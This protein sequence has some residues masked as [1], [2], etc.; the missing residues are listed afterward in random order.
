[1]KCKLTE[2][3]QAKLTIA[4]EIKQTQWR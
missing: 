4:K 2:Q 1:M 3:L